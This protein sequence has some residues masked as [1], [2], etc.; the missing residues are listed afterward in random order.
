MR[1]CACSARECSG[2]GGAEVRECCRDVGSREA[3]HD[4]G[5]CEVG[6]VKQRVQI[7]REIDDA[8]TGRDDLV[9]RCDVFC[10]HEG[11]PSAQARGGV[12]KDF[13]VRLCRCVANEVREIEHDRETRIGEF[14]EQ[15]KRLIGRLDDVGGFGL[16]SKCDAGVSGQLK[17]GP[18]GQSQVAMCLA[19]LVVRMRSPEVVGVSGARGQG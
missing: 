19:G 18:E 1:R 5:A 3:V 13:V 9:V 14:V 2:A 6:D 4:H 10:V 7:L 16:E 12:V 11:D 8:A 15:I 17:R